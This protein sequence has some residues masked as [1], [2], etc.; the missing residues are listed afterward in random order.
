MIVAAGETGAK[1]VFGMRLTHGFG[2]AIVLLDLGPPA[3]DLAATL[4]LEIG[5]LVIGARWIA[6]RV[7]FVQA[8]PGTPQSGRYSTRGTSRARKSYT[9]RILWL[10]RISRC[11]VSQ[12][13]SSGK[14][15]MGS[16]GTTSGSVR[17]M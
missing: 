3:R 1:P 13:G 11:T 5:Q 7:G 8:M 14:A 12:M 16:T 15:S 10:E 4:G 6:D 9:A 2:F 17:A